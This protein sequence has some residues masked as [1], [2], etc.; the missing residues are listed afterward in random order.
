MSNIT[1]FWKNHRFTILSWMIT[2]ALVA[3]ML[4]GA[5]WWKNVQAANSAYLPEPTAGP[6]NDAQNL[7]LPLPP[8]SG[9]IPSVM[10][11]IQLITNIPSDLPRYG[12]VTYTVQ[13]GDAMSMIAKKFDVT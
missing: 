7:N 9:A 4:G 1:S 3:S 10:R 6:S 13:R 8:V 12:P 2:I 5:L 11:R